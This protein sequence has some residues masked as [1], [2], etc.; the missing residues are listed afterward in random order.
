[1]PEA[2]FNRDIN[3]PMSIGKYFRLKSK[4]DKIKFL[5]ANTPH[6]ETKHWIS[7]KDT[8]LCDKYNGAPK[9]AKCV[10]CDKYKELYMSAGDDKKKIEEA[11][12]LRPTTT[13]F[14]PVLNLDTNEAVIF[15][16]AQ[17]VHWEIVGYFE[18]GVDVFGCAWSVERTE[19]PG[20]YYSTKRLDP[21]KLSLDQKEVFEEAKHINLKNKGQASSSVTP[22]EV[23][24]I[25]G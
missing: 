19:T 10:W 13:F 23:E 6:Y 8:V 2:G 15:Q 17:S 12:K 18:E 5:I 25:M 4:G 3:L 22:E 9:D 14:Y 20:N 21:V 11:N 16:T 1:M 7:D 24:K